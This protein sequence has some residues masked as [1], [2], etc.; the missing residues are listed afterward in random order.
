MDLLPAIII[1]ILITLPTGFAIVFCSYGNAADRREIY[2]LT[3]EL[4]RKESSASSEANSMAILYN[5]HQAEIADLNARHEAELERLGRANATEFTRGVEWERQRP[6]R[7]AK[8]EAQIARWEKKRQ[9]EL[10]QLAAE[11]S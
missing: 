2:R 9:A 3:Q 10:A 7:E 4:K 8:R 11:W 6:E 1:G 5:A